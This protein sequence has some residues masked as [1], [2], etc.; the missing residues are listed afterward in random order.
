MTGGHFGFAAV[1]KS[2][3][4]IVPLWALMLGTYLLD[5]IFIILNIAGIESFAPVDPEHPAYGGTLIQAAYSHSLVGAA[6]IA[7]AAG[8]L[9]YWAWGKRA[10][11]A[12]GGV[13]FSHWILDLLVHRPDLPVLPGN[14][15]DLPLLGFG[16]WQ[17][18][19]I[20]AI[21]ELAL[22]LAGAYL[23]YRS[24]IGAPASSGMERKMRTRAFT[25]A[26]ITA[27]FLLL[28]LAADVF[29][30]SLMLA[31][32]L[33]LLLVVFSG[34]LDARLNWGAPKS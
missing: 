24:A 25:A 32:S 34:W 16:L 9:A 4:P 27:L 22:V 6:L 21:I 11:L 20:S 5:V 2:R 28:L 3:A 18:P 29:N 31:V 15:G 26:G 19:V 23:Y 12:L 10:G 8:L 17:A 1:V 7:I 13:V 30:L 14:L 33:M